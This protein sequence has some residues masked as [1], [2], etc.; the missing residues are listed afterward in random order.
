MEI[1]VLPGKVDL[2]GMQ[3]GQSVVIAWGV[4]LCLIVFV[5]VVNTLIRKFDAIPRGF[6]NVLEM[7]M[8]ALQ[9]Y[10]KNQAGEEGMTLAPYIMTVGVYIAACCLVELLGLR[11]P[12]ADLS[13]TLALSLVSFGIIQ[14][15]G[16]HKKGWRRLKDYITPNAM[17]APIKL[18]TDIAVPISLSC[19]LFGNILAGMI[20]MELIYAVIPIAIPAALAIYFNLFHSLMQAYIFI[21]LT[22]SL[23]REAVE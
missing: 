6:Q 7:G 15:M 9:K 18:M 14:I 2:F 19:R 12:T 8:E 16:A 1:E 13:M 17:M 10:V 11:P 21:T 5:I 22:L 3:I 23:V 20:V 4:T